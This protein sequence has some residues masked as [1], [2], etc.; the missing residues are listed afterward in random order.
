LNAA[1]LTLL[2]TVAAALMMAHQVAGKAVRDSFFLSAYSAADLPK[3]VTAAAAASILL[4]L[5]FTRAM[6]RIGPRLLVPAGFLVSAAVHVTEYAFAPRA[7]G[8]WAVAIYLHIVGLGS[9]LLSGF[10]SQMSETFELRTAKQVFGRIAGAGTFGGVLGGLAAE[11]VAAL[12]SANDVLLLLAGLHLACAV[13]LTAAHGSA[14]AGDARTQPEPVSRGTLLSRAPYL[15]TFAMVVTCGTA[16][17]AMADYLFKAGAGA[18]FGKGAPLLRFFAVF[19]TSTQ[20]LTF[21]SQ[22]ALAERFLR[23]FGIARSIG[24]L[25]G[26]M[27]AGALGALLLPAFPAFAALR[28]L[29]FTLRGSLYRSGYELLYAPVPPVEKRAAKT[30]IDV[31][32]DRAG[33]ALGSLVVQCALLAGGVFLSSGLLGMVM[34]VS[35]A[36][37]WA[38]LRLDIIYSA[39]VRQRMIDRAVELDLDQADDLTTRSVVLT[40]QTTAAVGGDLVIAAP[41]PVPPPADPP[42]STLI[43]LRSGDRERVLQAI[44]RIERPEPLLAIQLTR[45]LAWDE[46]SAEAAAALRHEPVAVTGLLIDQLISSATPFGTRRRIPRLLAHCEH[47]LAVE[48]L[49]AGLDDARFEVRF[50]CARALD[51]LHQRRPDLALDVRRVFAAV[52][53]ELRTARP[54]WESRRLLDQ[55]DPG[56]PQA[57]F[58]DVLRERAN[59]SLE[60]VFSL[61]ATVLAREAVITAFRAL[62]TD[63]ALLR[64]LAVEYL[65]GVLPLEIR[66]RLWE[67]VEPGPGAH[68]ERS[69]EAV[70]DELLRSQQSLLLQL[71]QD[72]G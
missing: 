64:G 25:P 16:A 1:R 35:L 33:D 70:V 21:L 63:D 8:P 67:L 9:I 13:S 57:Y 54:V 52:E 55:R 27:A 20:V 44:R 51:A 43:E 24:T 38:A 41:M 4:V 49:L 65:D 3:M 14:A 71:K 69:P 72:R 26:G 18:A 56:D 2:A 36:G 29:E 62:H 5:L 15:L 17:A 66:A 60:H 12:G 40:L 47:Q 30:W 11:R 61:F 31:G 10:W 48:G 37:T 19:Y 7:P 34:L 32:C 42:L 53:R 58:D 6:E 23:R 45:L 46:V 28:G 68:A 50:Q 39:L 59:Q 22:T